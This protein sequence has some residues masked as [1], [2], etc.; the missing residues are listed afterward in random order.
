MTQPARSRDGVPRHPDTTFDGM[1]AAQEELVV[2][3]LDLDDTGFR[4]AVYWAYAM[5]PRT[6]QQ[7]RDGVAFVRAALPPEWQGRQAQLLRPDVRI[8][9]RWQHDFLPRHAG[10]W[11]Y[12]SGILV[13]LQA[14]QAS[15]LLP[16]LTQPYQS[17]IPA[18]LTG[19]Y[20]DALLL[21][22]VAAARPHL[23]DLFET[24]LWEFGGS[25]EELVT[26]AE[27]LHT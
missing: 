11:N 14:A 24:L 2:R 3:V 17:D 7:I 8:Y 20:E 23:C 16:E 1:R 5:K 27:Q 13:A 12:A 10:A 22:E 15:V 9:D 25:A 21:A 6:V 4:F 26:V 18:Q 19:P